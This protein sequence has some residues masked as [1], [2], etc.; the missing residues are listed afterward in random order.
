L[1]DFLETN[2]NG[3]L[4]ARNG[5]TPCGIIETRKNNKWNYEESKQG[6]IQ[7]KNLFGEMRKQYAK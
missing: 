4:F 3:T 5:N 1:R 6:E 2:K 7:R